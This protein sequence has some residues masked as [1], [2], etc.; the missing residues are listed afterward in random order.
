[1]CV[2]DKGFVLGVV[3]RYFSTKFQYVYT[4]TVYII[5]AEQEPGKFCAFPSIIVII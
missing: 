2:N 4:E 3:L 1:M 5:L